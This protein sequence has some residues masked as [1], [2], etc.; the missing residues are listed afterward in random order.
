MSY[1]PES[2]WKHPSHLRKCAQAR[3]FNMR[4]TIAKGVRR[5]QR[6]SFME[7]AILVLA[8][9]ILASGGIVI[10]WSILSLFHII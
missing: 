10:G 2:W 9:L 7:L 1:V 6:E 8:T 3:D 4:E 5:L